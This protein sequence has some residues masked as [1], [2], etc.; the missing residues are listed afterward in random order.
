MTKLRGGEGIIAQDQKD[1]VTLRLLV[2]PGYLSS[3]QLRALAD[4]VDRE[5][6]GKI[7]LTSRK[8]VQVPWIKFENAM[9]VSSELEMFGLPPGS[10]GRKVRTIMTCAGTGRCPFVLY[11]VDGLC[12]KLNQGYYGSMMPTKFKISLAGCPNSCSNPYINDFGVIGADI[13]RLIEEKCIKCGVC[14]RYCRGDAIEPDADE[15]PIIDFDKCIQCGWCIKNCPSGALESDKKGFSLIVGGKSGRS[16]ALGQKI[17]EL[18]SEDELFEILNNILKYFKKHAKGRERI[19][20]IIKR[21]GID[22]LKS[23]V[24]LKKEKVDETR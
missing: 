11:D 2:S 6:N 8:G 17:A 10:C 20:E 7:I 19:S 9:D 15:L 23:E 5:G 4:I 12:N 16:P 3:D 21:N 22:H 1:F 14:S 18:V 13:P 24:L